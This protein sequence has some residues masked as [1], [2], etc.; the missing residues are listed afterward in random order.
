[1]AGLSFKH[2]SAIHRLLR[3]RNDRAPLDAVWRKIHVDFEVGEPLG[4]WLYFTSEHRH[5]LREQARREWGFDPLDALPDGNRRTVAAVAIDE[6]L[7][8][9][10]PDQ[11]HVLVKGTLPAPL[12]CLAPELSLRVPL[13]SLAMAGIEQVVV[14]ENLDSFDHWQDHALPAELA[15]SL[16]LY[17]GHNGVASG[18]GQ[19]LRRLPTEVRVVVFADW[20]PAGLAIA[21]GLPRADALLVPKLEANLLAKGSREHYDRQFQAARQLDGSPLHGWRGIWEEMKSWRVSIKQQHMLAL[22]SELRLIGRQL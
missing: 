10:R 12:P 7:A 11:R 16:V 15:N 6:K 2:L 9:E 17:R 8:S 14:V 1:M 13:S 18:T 19:L 5:L 22:G 3:E 4:Q 21:C 20:D